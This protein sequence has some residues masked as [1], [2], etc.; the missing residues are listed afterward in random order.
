MLYVGHASFFTC[1]YAER[2]ETI[3]LYFI[4]L[5]ILVPRN[6]LRAFCMLHYTAKKH[7]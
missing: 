6:E 5:F 3:M 2:E 4:C 7:V 1:L